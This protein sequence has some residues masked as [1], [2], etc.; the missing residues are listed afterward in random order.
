MCNRHRPTKRLSLRLDIPPKTSA[1]HDVFIDTHLPASIAHS[2][3]N[4][5]SVRSHKSSQYVRLPAFLG[6][7]FHQYLCHP[8]ATSP[9]A[10]T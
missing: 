5:S 8:A 4:R 9:A 3:S 2:R 10:I 6:K 1:L 7:C